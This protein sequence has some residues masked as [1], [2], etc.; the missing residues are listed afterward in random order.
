MREV[1]DTSS[2]IRTAIGDPDHYRL[3]VVLVGDPETGAKR[4]RT[5][6]GDVSS[7]VH[8]LAIGHCPPSIGVPLP[9]KRGHTATRCGGDV[10][11]QNSGEG[12]RCEC[13]SFEHFAFA[14][15]NSGI[16]ATR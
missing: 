3:A 6:S 16:T 9:I 1:E 13:E 7:G 14:G 2:V 15:N 8:G 11:G 4:K 10:A 5:V 12:Q